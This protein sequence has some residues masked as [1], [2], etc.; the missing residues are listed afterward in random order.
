M[1]FL[2]NTDNTYYEADGINITL[3]LLTLLIL[4]TI[5]CPRYRCTNWGTE[6]DCILPRVK[7]PTTVNCRHMLQLT[8]P[9][10]TA[11]Y[12]LEPLTLLHFILPLNRCHLQLSFSRLDLGNNLSSLFLIPHIQ[13]SDFSKSVSVT[14]RINL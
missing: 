12:F 6:K 5:S 11:F 2:T 14:N 1:Y 8:C 9:K 10:L 13:L 4:V 7:L 3:K